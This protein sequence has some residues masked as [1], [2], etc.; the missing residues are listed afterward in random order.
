VNNKGQI[1]GYGTIN[2]VDHA[3]LLTP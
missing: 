1:V 2:G 3:F